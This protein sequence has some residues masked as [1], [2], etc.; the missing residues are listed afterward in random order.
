MTT[1]FPVPDR[2]SLAMPFLTALLAAVIFVVDTAT[3]LDGA[4][5]V[6]YVAVVLLAMD[7]AS[8][9][10]IL[11]VA[12]GCGALTLL[13]F[14]IS[15][16]E[17]ADTGPIMRG[18]VSL[19]AIGITALLAARNQR[20]Q[21]TVREHASLLDLTHD[22]IFVRNQDDVVTYWNRAAT[23]L[24]GWTAGEARGRKAA[25][26]LH[27]E[28]PA[29]PADITAGLLRDGRW[30]GELVHRAR[31]GRRLVVA[32]RWAVQRDP[33]GRL[34][35]VLETNNDVTERRGI[36]DGLHRAQSELAHVSRVA[37]LGE[38]T[39]S[40]AHEVNQPLAAI[41]TNGE[42]GLRWL[43][44]PVPDIAEARQSVEH[45]IRNAQRASEV[46][47]R[48]RGLSRR[49]GPAHDVLAPAEVAHEVGLLIARELTV[50][51]VALSVAAPDDL[52]RVRG[53]RVQLQQ[54]IMNL[55]M[56]GIQAMAEVEDRP[57]KLT[58]E[59]GR[60]GGDVVIAVTDSGP[61]LDPAQQ[62]RLFEAFFTTKQDGMGM[63][64]S[65]CRSI[66][67][68]HGGS[69]RAENVEGGACFRVTLPA[70]NEASHAAP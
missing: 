26:L 47:R 44:R 4:I 39:A 38:L 42:A 8:E 66:I 19:A 33:R 55:L 28:F 49:D 16:G 54:V 36:E 34:A 52:P 50:R 13:S 3:P 35:A 61:G 20:S 31:D 56:N 70:V 40:I 10:G 51:R 17:S 53:D 69:I 14:A 37:T 6:L 45:M 43:G 67:E 65:I 41:V 1:R 64:L 32:S 11:F 62:E 23:D 24:Y 9:R 48:L 25:E 58:I 12:A 22:A 21:A 59:L 2:S 68:A 60:S 5:A 30:E 18:L 29:P 27:T 46:V 57:R 7:F 63:G 15:H